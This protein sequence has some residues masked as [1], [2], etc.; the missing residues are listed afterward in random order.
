MNMKK[1]F[2]VM[3]VLY[4]GIFA[5]NKKLYDVDGA[6]KGNNFLKFENILDA[7]DQISNSKLASTILSGGYFTIGT[8]GGVSANSLDDNCTITY[9]HPYAK[10]SYPVISIDG[11]WYKLDDFFKPSEM[12]I[13]IS[14]D[15]LK[16]TAIQSGYISYVFKICIKNDGQGIIFQQSVKNLDST[17]HT[18]ACGFVFDPALAKNGDGYLELPD[19]FL[20][21]NRIFEPGTIPNNLILWERAIGAKG[22]GIQI[23]YP[24][25]QPEKIIAANWDEIYKN[26]GPQTPILNRTLYDLVIELFG[27]AKNLNAN[28]SISDELDVSLL[29]PDFSSSLFL[30]WD[31]Q[32]YL[33]VQSGQL[34][35]QNFNTFLEINK[36]GGSSNS[37]VSVDLTLPSF[38]TSSQTS[39]SFNLTGEQ[40]LD[41]IDLTAHIRYEEKIEEVTAKVKSGN[42]I[43][44]E[45]HRMIYMPAIP[46]SDTGLVVKIDTLVVSKFP[47]LDIKFEAQR[48]ANGSKIVDLTPENIFLYEE[49]SRIE[50][51]TMKK[52]TSGGVNFADIIFVLDVTGSM[53]GTIDQVKKNITVFAD[54]LSLRGID[55][56]LGMVTF[57][58]I[59]ENKYPFTKDVALFKSQ[60]DLQYAHGG[61]DEP[62]NSLQ[63]LLDA[64]NYPFRLN[65][66]R[67]IIWITDATYHEKDS[68]TSLQKSDVISALLTNSIIVNSIGPT[69]NKSSWYDP[70][71]GPTGGKFYDISGNFKDILTDISKFKVASK[72][73]LSFISGKTSLP[74]KITIQIKYSGL[75]GEATINN[76]KTNS[77]QLAK[78]LSFYPNPFNPQI[79]FKVNKAGITNGSIFIYNSI[80]QLVKS[81]Q[82]GKD[83]QS[84]NWNGRNEK[85]ELIAS[86]FYIVQ[87]KLSDEAT[88]GYNEFAKILF[89]K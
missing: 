89:L 1:I 88:Q 3:L 79:T 74:G 30:R 59:V 36:N 40:S 87:L 54:S 38:L 44:D 46:V 37:N 19:G 24:G 27:K 15:T 83:F 52:D 85:G 72:Y 84:I 31:L 26:A 8:T 68:F 71:I 62:E 86:G 45:I 47:N 35:P 77:L 81:F 48:K 14:F 29:Q 5:Q 75:G 60:V 42:S 63:A 13:A 64:S 49:S 50:N 56:R 78:I 76:S 69:F 58:D 65:C 18:L 11:K 66:N 73:I 2:F 34:F 61:G 51:F 25:E 39:G 70:I 28:Q 10:T 53:G 22:I 6:E 67:V 41:K 33:T 20:G 80:G 4:S 82:I 57:L 23:D 9:G 17:P 21:G 16:L 55:F 32:N 43:L 12:N 7:T